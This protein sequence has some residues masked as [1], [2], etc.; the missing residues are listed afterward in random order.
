MYHF[1]VVN[2]E[3]LLSLDLIYRSFCLAS[4]RQTGLC[5]PQL[6]VL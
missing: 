4:Q 1:D 3:I 6:H 5:Q 2:D